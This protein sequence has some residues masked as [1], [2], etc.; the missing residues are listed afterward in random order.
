LPLLLLA[1][2]PLLL[3]GRVPF[4]GRV[5]LRELLV[6]PVRRET[7]FNPTLEGALQQLSNRHM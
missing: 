6:E 7:D 1:P 4:C 2:L 3:R 5:L